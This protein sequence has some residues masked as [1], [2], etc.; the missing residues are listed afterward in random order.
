[1]I[2][3]IA[4]AQCVSYLNDLLKNKKTAFILLTVTAMI[5]LVK[6]EKISVETVRLTLWLVLVKM[7]QIGFQMDLRIELLWSNCGFMCLC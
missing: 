3:H 6:L 5:L 2:N 4:L 1:M 7:I